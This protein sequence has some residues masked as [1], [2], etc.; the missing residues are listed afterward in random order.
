MKKF[1]PLFFFFVIFIF[2]GDVRAQSNTAFEK[3][4]LAEINSLRTN[5]ATYAKWI[6]DNRKNLPYNPQSGKEKTIDEAI[7]ALKL[8]APL[9]PLTVSQA[10][11]KAAKSHVDNQL[12][13]GKFSHN[14]TDGSTA[15]S[16]LR[17]FGKLTG[18]YGENAIA[19][20]PNEKG[21]V[22]AKGIVPAWV[23]DDYVGNRA[24]RK[25]LLD[26]NFQF[27]GAG[28]G[29]YSSSKI[30]PEYTLCVVDFAQQIQ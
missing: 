3:E 25:F 15:D 10:A 28:C 27:V 29:K 8:T 24:H 23:I 26:K 7:K 22:E 13:T 9:L 18:N 19:M 21:I 17:R 2:S 14:G 30:Y 16:R 11:T 20:N 6:E 4:I 1:L 5:P 12:P